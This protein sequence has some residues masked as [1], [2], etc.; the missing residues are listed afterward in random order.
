LVFGGRPGRARACEL[1][2]DDRAAVRVCE[3]G[4]DS[5][6]S[7]GESAREAEEED[8][9]P[10]S[11][12]PDDDFL[13][14]ASAMYSTATLPAHKEVESVSSSRRIQELKEE[15]KLEATHRSR[16]AL[17]TART[18][19]TRAASRRTC[20]RANARC[21]RASKERVSRR[22]RCLAVQAS[23]DARGEKGRR[24]GVRRADSHEGRVGVGACAL[25]V[26][27]RAPLVEVALIESPRLE[28]G[29]VGVGDAPADALLEALVALG[30]CLR[31]ER[32]LWS[33]EDR[34]RGGGE[35]EDEG[36]E[37]EVHG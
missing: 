33:C 3:R 25:A 6:E 18:A 37:R 17:P 11:L 27:N 31:V 7:V 1:V 8:A 15:E 4:K 10:R 16:N 21:L 2:L 28:V 23:R 24:T 12:R 34:C 19:S 9:Q 5:A 26:G 35:G 13:R 29:A 14:P 32:E 22:Q 36:D 30:E 20:S